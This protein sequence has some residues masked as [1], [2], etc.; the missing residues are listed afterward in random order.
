MSSPAPVAAVATFVVRIPGEPCGQGRP[1]AFKTPQGFI[2][3][4]DPKKSRNW[5]AAARDVMVQALA[6]G[7][8]LHPVGPLEVHLLA[9]FSCPPSQYRKRD[10]WPRRWHAKRPDAEN[11]C[12][13]VLDAGTGVL[14]SDDAQIAQLFVTKAIGAQG[15][16]PYVEVRVGPLGSFP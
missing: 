1:R 16:S 10:P 5:K 14:W 11:V 7:A 13:A 3:T 12:K 4:Y 15:E 9:I 2:R 8:I 6:G